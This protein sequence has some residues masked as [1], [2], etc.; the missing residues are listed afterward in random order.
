MVY[1]APG[2]TLPASM[3]MQAATSE[4]WVVAALAVVLVFFASLGVW[5]YLVCN[6]HVQECYADWWNM[7]A[8]AKCYR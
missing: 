3:E 4:W 6:G 5:C 7:R 1:A 2:L 8:V